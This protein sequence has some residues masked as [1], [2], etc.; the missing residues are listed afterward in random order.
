VDNINHKVVTKASTHMYLRLDAI[1][2]RTEEWIS[3]SW[4][5]GKWAP[6]SVVNSQGEVIDGRLKSGL[7]PSAITRDLKWG[8][9]VP[10]GGGDEEIGTEGKVICK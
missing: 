5:A 9:P 8:V 10:E 2:P 4:K 1:Q 3:K 7:K 6:N